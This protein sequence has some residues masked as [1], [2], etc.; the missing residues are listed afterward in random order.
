MVIKHDLCAA[1]LAHCA[2]WEE[3]KLGSVLKH[4]KCYITVKVIG[5]SRTGN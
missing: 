3:V 5:T 2:I 4:C 1:R